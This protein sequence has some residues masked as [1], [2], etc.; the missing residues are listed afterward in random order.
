MRNILAFIFIACAGAA[1]AQGRINKGET[2]Y[3][4][5]PGKAL[6]MQYEEQN[7]YTQTLAGDS[8]LFEYYK[9]NDERAEMSDDEYA[10]KIVF[11]VARN[12]KAFNYTGET[13]KAAFLRSCFC[14]DRGW[15]EISDG[16]IKG[17]KI[18]ATTWQIEMDVMTKADPSR[19]A[20]AVTRRL[21]AMFKVYRAPAPKTKS[22]AKKK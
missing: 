19:N 6:R 14:P 4:I 18:N 2:W 16:F 12:A 11:A 10:E 7:F 5:Y 15:H 8:L 22:T 9:R 20:Q 3:R 21:K 1:F 13:L 17:K